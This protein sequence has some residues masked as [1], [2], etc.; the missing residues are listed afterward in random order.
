MSRASVPDFPD[1][2]IGSVIGVIVLIG[3]RRILALKG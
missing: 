1:L 3:A 2:L